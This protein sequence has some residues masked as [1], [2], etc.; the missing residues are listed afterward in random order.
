[1]DGKKSIGGR[2]CQNVRG[3]K[4]LGA[5]FNQGIISSVFSYAGED[6]SICSGLIENIQLEIEINTSSLSTDWKKLE[7]SLK[8]KKDYFY[9]KKFPKA[10]VKIEGAKV[11][12]DD[13]Y[14]TDAILTLKG[15]TRSVPLNFTI[16]GNKVKA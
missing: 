15:I 1:M 5:D 8:K 2:P 10:T 11:K 3:S 16:D 7:S 9:I 6:Y 12:G 13:Q 14:T 4:G